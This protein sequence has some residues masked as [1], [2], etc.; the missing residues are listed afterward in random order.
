GV[1]ANAVLNIHSLI[2]KVAEEGKT[3]FLTSHNL[4][5]VE[6]LC[7]EIAI[8]DKGVIQA[9][10]S[11]KQLRHKYLSQLTV[12]VKHTAIPEEHKAGLQQ[13]FNKISGNIKWST[14]S[15]TLVVEE[16]ASIP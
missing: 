2:K 12:N 13:I 14:G 9:Q 3:I 8:M 11:M 15:T 16:E 6:K 7:D 1:D 5:E 10:G 4:D